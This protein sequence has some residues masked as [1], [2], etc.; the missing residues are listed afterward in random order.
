MNKTDRDSVIEY[1]TQLKQLVHDPHSFLTEL[2]VQQQQ[3]Y[4]IGW[5]CHFDVLSFIPLPPKAIS[6]DEVAIQAKVPLSTLQ[7]V[8]RMAM[9]AGFLCETKDRRLSHNVLSSHFVTDVHMRT[10]L[11]YMF[12]QTVPIMAALKNATQRWG[13][14]S[15]TN[16]TA[17]NIVYNTDLSFFKYLKTHPDLNELFHAY[18][19]SRAVSHTGSN[20]EHL[21]GG[22]N[23]KDLGQATVVDAGI[24]I[25]GLTVY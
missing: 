12:N 4:C 1:A 7:S 23:W 25:P 8:A 9:T 6:Y 15:A 10:Q 21:L 17:Y 13:S 19:K 5:L 24:S 16:E 20:V 2:V 3:Y 18:M 11:L 22:F 14:T